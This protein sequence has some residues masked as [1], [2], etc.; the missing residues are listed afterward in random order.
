[1]VLGI[2]LM[3]GEVFMA[4][5]MEDG[6]ILIMADTHTMGMVIEEAIHTED[7]VLPIIL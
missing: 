3:R 4:V 2:R 6:I 5:T 1:M 7:E